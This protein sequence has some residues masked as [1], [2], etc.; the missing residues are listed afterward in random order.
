[1]SAVR[2]RPTP[3]KT[4]DKIRGF[5]VRMYFVYVLLSPS[6]GKTYTGYTSDVE[7]RLL[8]HNVTETTGFT[9]R[10]RPGY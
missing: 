8:E 1:M 3:P 2:S 5:L 6:S 4:S 10:Y 9:L 7:R